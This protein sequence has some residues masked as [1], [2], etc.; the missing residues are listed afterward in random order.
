MLPYMLAASRFAH[1]IKVMMRERIGSFSTGQSVQDFLNSWIS[2]Y[3]LLDDTAPSAVKARFPLREARITVTEDE[4]K[5]GSFK[6]TVF[7]RPHFQL[8]ELSTSIRLVAELPA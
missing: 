1:Y 8:E 2:Q 7:L 4:E 5:V 3:V 6:A